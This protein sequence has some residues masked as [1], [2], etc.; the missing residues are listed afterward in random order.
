MQGAFAAVKQGPY[1]LDDIQQRISS[2]TGLPVSRIILGTTHT[3]AG[4]DALGVF[5]GVPESYLRLLADRYT[6]A[7]IAAWQ[8][9]APATLTW[10]AV[11]APDMLQNQSHVGSSGSGVGSATGVDDQSGLDDQLRVLEADD[12]TTGE[13]IAFLPNWQ[14]HPSIV[15]GTKL[16]PDWPGILNGV[17]ESRYPG[18]FSM[19]VPGDV[20]RTQTG[21]Q[22]NTDEAVGV[23]KATAYATELANR[24]TAALATDPHPVPAGPVTANQVFITEDV[25][26][27][28]LLAVYYGGQ[29]GVT[30]IYRSRAYPWEQG[31]DTIGTRVFTARIGDLLFGA[32]PGEAY[33]EIH[34][35]LAGLTAT[36][37]TFFVGLA[38]DQLGYLISPQEDYP[39]V[40]ANGDDNVLLS[41]SP[42]IGDHVECSL[43][44]G[45]KALGFSVGTM[46]PSAFG[47]AVPLQ[48]CDQWAGEQPG[49]GGP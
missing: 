2:A 28:A 7:A 8:D 24:L 3:H 22:G 27:A 37:V 46:P 43:L 17:L 32:V 16:D 4:A 36:P 6:E 26:G 25:S 49:D 35:A 40:A 29:D 45:A 14:G 48:R 33:P 42:S 5:G 13:P 10:A 31:P 12:P 47:L 21:Q 20:G 1:G 38:G 23:Q 44:K 41:V 18:A 19:A 9:R 30:S 34:S 39:I 15:P 11:H